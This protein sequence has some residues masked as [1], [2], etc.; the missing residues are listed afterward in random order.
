MVKSKTSETKIRQTI[1]EI[2][3]NKPKIPEQKF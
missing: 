3:E 1:E 2:A